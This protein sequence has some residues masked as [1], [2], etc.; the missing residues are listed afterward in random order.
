MNKNELSRSEFRKRA[1]EQHSSCIIPW[2]EKSIDDVHHILERDLWENGG[3]IQGN[4]APVCNRHHRYAEENH[5][6]PQAFWLWKSIEENAVKG[7]N[8]CNIDADNLKEIDWLSEFDKWDYLNESIP[9]P[10]Q[11]KNREIPAHL[12][13]KAVD[14]WGDDFVLPQ[15]KEYR[16]RIKYQSSRHLMPLYWHDETDAGERIENDDTEL[17]TIEDFIGIPLVITHKMD[18]CLPYNQN[19]LTKEKGQVP[20]GTIVNQELDVSVKSYNQDTGEIQY[21]PVTN[22]YRNGK[23]DE[24]LRIEHDGRYSSRLIVTPN[25]EIYQPDG[26]TVLAGDLEAGDEFVISRISLSYNQKELIYGSMLGDASI[27]KG[28]NKNSSKNQSYLLKETHSAKKQGKYIDWKAEMLGQ[29]LSSITTYWS[30]YDKNHDETKKKELTTKAL[31]EF[32]K[33]SDFI[34]DTDNG[35]T[36]PS[37]LEL[38]PK[39]IAVWYCDDGSCSDTTVQRPRAQFH[40]QG[41]SHHSCEIL[42]EKLNQYGVTGRVANYGK[43]PRIEISADGTEELFKT[44]GSYIPNCMKYKVPNRYWSQECQWEKSNGGLST[45]EIERI[46]KANPTSPVKFDIEV[47]DNHNYFTSEILVSNS[48]CMLINDVDN[49]VRARRGSGPTDTMKPLYRD[50][51]LYWTH[52]VNQRLPDRLQVFGEWLYSKHS[53]HYGCECKPA[54]E[55]IG[56]SLG[57]LTD[58]N[59][60]A[61]YFQV[62]GVF[63]KRLDIWLDWNTT[64]RVANEL[65]FPTVP[66]IHCEDHNDEATFETEH[67]ARQTLLEYAHNVIDNGGEGIVVRSKFPFHYGQFGI[68]LGKYVR[69]NHVDKD[70]DH[71]QHTDTTENRI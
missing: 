33:L 28:G 39:T 10:K 44:I 66:V 2:C 70:A 13:P 55:D 50:G 59:D 11:V 23:T 47:K 60:D 27:S 65:G 29:A 40:T 48:N 26:S 17:N 53:I 16:E 51:G 38:T 34:P 18:G 4:D 42:L 19:I 8:W 12:E 56:P 49:P 68:R 61:A 46:T 31:P 6:P 30:Q 1:K 3:Y 69:E 5:I 20:I 7:L 62:F 67:E 57:E 58:H 71:C 21:R 15:A 9:L 35:R 25:H 36:I 64:Q 22:Y 24:W 63:D 41:F 54:C 45:V 32:D 43:G 52:M 14:K 37:W